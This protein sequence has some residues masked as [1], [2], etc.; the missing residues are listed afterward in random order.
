VASLCQI[1]TVLAGN[2]GGVRH[3]LRNMSANSR[4]LLPVTVDYFGIPDRVPDRLGQ[5]LMDAPAAQGSHVIFFTR[6]HQ[7]ALV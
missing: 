3:A 1:P 5:G 6:H 4:F 2:N 7:E